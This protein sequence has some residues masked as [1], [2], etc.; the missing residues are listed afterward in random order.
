MRPL[1]QLQSVEKIYRMGDVYLSA[2]RGVSVTFREGEMTAVIGPSGSGKS[3]VMHIL[4]CLDRPTSG[5]YLLEGRNVAHLGDSQLSEIRNRKIGFVF[6]ARQPGDWRLL[7]CLAPPP[8]S[9][10]R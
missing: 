4:G 7:G 3:T 2:L 8:L 10:Q 6:P 1:M 5:E 9:C